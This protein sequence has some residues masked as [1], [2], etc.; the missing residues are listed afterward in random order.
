MIKFKNITKTYPASRNSDKKVV[1]DD[2]SFRLKKNEILALMG[3][4]GSGK[5]TIARL[6]LG[7]EKPDRGSIIYKNINLCS[8]T[9]KKFKPYRKDIQFISQDPSSFFDPSIKIGKSIIE[10]L[11][12]FNIP[13]SGKKNR[14]KNLLE[15][16]KL[17]EKILERYPHQVSGGEIQ[18]AS[19]LRV[20]LLEPK[21]L[22]LDEVTSMLDI[23]VQAQVLHILKQVKKEYQM[24][25]LFISHDREVVDIFADRTIELDRGK[26]KQ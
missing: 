17:D 15:D 19:I 4:S 10:P 26:I 18:R 3:S 11:N 12:N 21:I 5:T 23:S 7:L 13:I 2:L 1:L 9:S 24:S 8:L 14:I 16:L 22:I 25:Y 6:I 20:L